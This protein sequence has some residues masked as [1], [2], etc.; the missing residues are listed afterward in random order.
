MKKTVK[1]DNGIRWKFKTVLEDIDFADDL[2]L[3]SSKKKLIQ[4]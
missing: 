3:L 4:E 1:N 2:P